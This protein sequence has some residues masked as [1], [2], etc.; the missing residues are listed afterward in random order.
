MGSNPLLVVSSDGPHRSEPGVPEV[1][2]G[3][4]GGDVGASPRAPTSTIG[5]PR[6]PFALL[7]GA[8][9][10]VDA[11]TNEPTLLFPKPSRRYLTASQA[12]GLK[13]AIKG[14]T[15]WTAE[16]ARYLKEDRTDLVDPLFERYHSCFEIDLSSLLTPGET[17]AATHSPFKSLPQDRPATAAAGKEG[18]KEEKASKGAKLA[19]AAKPQTPVP[20]DDTTPP[21]D[22]VPG[23]TGPVREALL[24]PQERQE[25]KKA[26]PV[27]DGKDL[28][29]NGASAWESSASVL[30]LQIRLARPLEAKWEPPPPPEI[31]L[32]TLIPERPVVEARK[33]AVQV[34][35]EAFQVSHQVR[36]SQFCFPKY[37]NTQIAPKGVQR[38]PRIYTSVLE[39]QRPC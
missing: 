15:K 11:A 16:I 36:L 3:P 29:E 23:Q 6:E 14:G 35:L 21:V 30:P 1:E 12:E 8:T 38:N 4:E 34:A 13:A 26:K 9:M 24:K 18:K 31:D 32:R 39:A 28:P 27:E 2:R 19:T 20:K 17:V 7:S 22:P 37:V 10:A 25:N 33:D 5:P